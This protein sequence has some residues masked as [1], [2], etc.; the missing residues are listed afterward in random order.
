MLKTYLITVG[1][2]SLITFTAFAI[3]KI[4]SKKET[5]SRVPELALLSMIGFGGAV[6]GIL[7]MYIFRHKT[8]FKTKFHFIISAWLAL[9]TQAAIAIYLGWVTL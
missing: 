8:I 2:V 5:K 6:G 1:I 7:G 9:A 3:D 4:K